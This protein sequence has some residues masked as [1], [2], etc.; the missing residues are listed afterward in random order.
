MTMDKLV[1][2]SS[3]VI[4]WFV[5]ESLTEEARRVLEGY[6]SGSFTLIAPDLLAAEIGNIV[7]KKSA[8]R[9]WPSKTRSKLLLHFKN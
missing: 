2:D 1:V 3:V 7:W 5:T 8:F 9:D 4:K 6:Q